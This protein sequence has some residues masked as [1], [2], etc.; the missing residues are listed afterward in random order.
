[1]HEV[2][3]QMVRKGGGILAADESTGTM[4]KRLEGVGLESTE[5]SRNEYR[6]TIFETPDLNKYIN[7]VILYDETIRNAEIVNVL[8]NQNILIGIKVDKGQKRNWGGDSNEQVTQGLD[9]LYERLVEYKALGATFT[10]WRATYIIE[11]LSEPSRAAIVA[12]AHQLAMYASISQAAGLVPIVEPEV[13]MDGSHSIYKAFAVTQDVQHEVFNQLNIQQ[14]R[15]NEMVLKP[16]MVL[17]GYDG[18]DIKTHNTIAEMTVECLKNT[19]PAAVPGIAFLSGGQRPKEAT[20]RLRA[21]N[22]I[23]DYY[24]HPWNLTFSFGRALQQ[25]ALREWADNYLYEDARKAK[26]QT[27]LSTVAFQNSQATKG[28]V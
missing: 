11:P 3:K 22:R 18:K 24:H 19:V 23:D 8:N 13:L 4:T 7:G 1:M 25:Q 20:D 5:Q 10:K 21:M 2:A 26:T 9:D 14:V 6:Q 15:L 16:N 12:N 28:E 17:S 27:A